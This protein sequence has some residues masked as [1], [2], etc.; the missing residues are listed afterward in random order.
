MISNG[1]TYA[2]GKVLIKSINEHLLPTT[3]MRR[4]GWPGPPVAAPRTRD[5]HIDLFC[6]LIPGQALITEL[7][8]LVWRRG[9]LEDTTTHGDPGAAQLIAK[10][11]LREAQLGTNLAQ[12]P[13]LGVQ[14]GCTV[15]V[16][17]VTVTSL[18]LTSV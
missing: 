16:Y 4:L 5:S 6:H 1:C 15:N 14:V 17:D 8:D 9:G 12:G 7:Q 13:A 2:N 18:Y 3:P 11:G 10:G